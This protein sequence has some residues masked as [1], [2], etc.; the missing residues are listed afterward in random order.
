MSGELIA[1]LR[2]ALFDVDGTLCDSAPLHFEAWRRTLADHGQPT[3]IW[4]EYVKRCLRE[5]RRFEEIL[6]LPSDEAAL[7]HREKSAHFAAL[8][9]RELRALPGVEAFWQRL[10]AL[11]V[12]IGIVSTARRSSVQLAL[13]AMRLPA[14]DIVVT[15]EDVEPNVKPHPAG[16]QLTVARLGVP[17]QY[18]IAFEDAPSGIAAARAA[19]LVCFAAPSKVF[20]LEDQKEA[21]VRFG[22]WSAVRLEQRSGRVFVVWSPE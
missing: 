13:R 10:R 16:Y 18:A 2:A 12:A 17:A 3:P 7:L 22:S 19:G 5:Q 21:H 15:R 11:G 4:D 14:P 9:E 1:D 20:S 8:A 6:D